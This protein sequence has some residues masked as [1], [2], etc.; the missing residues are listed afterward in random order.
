MAIPVTDIP[1]TNQ[2]FQRPWLSHFKKAINLDDLLE[3]MPESER[4]SRSYHKPKILE[5]LKIFR[6]Y[7]SLNS[8]IN[9]CLP[10]SSLK[11]NKTVWIPRCEARRILKGRADEFLPITTDNVDDIDGTT[12]THNLA[13]PGPTMEMVGALVYTSSAVDTPT[14]QLVDVPLR[15]T[16]VSDEN[17]FV[18]TDGNPVHICVCGDNTYQGMR[19][20][21]N[22][23]YLACQYD[24]VDSG[25]LSGII[26]QEVIVDGQAV[27]VVDF[28]NAIRLFAYFDSNGS[29][30]A[31]AA[32]EWCS[33]MIFSVQYSNAGA[34]R[35]ARMA[36]DTCAVD[37]PTIAGLEDDLSKTIGDSHVC[38]LK[39]QLEVSRL[40][41]QI[42]QMQ[43]AAHT[44]PTA[45][46]ERFHAVLR[47][48][49]ANAQ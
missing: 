18:D 14:L 48:C 32:M 17:E 3:A 9:E 25:D 5:K 44:L 36:A 31:M 38:D 10:L 23:I 37:G 22:H 33:R 43:L 24:H 4:P 45:A 2:V 7:V 35:P 28:R 8:D 42:S 41:A 30:L 47:S 13:Q 6:F 46:R 20:F 49:D 1:T 15:I 26:I 11:R 27:R 29:T 16:D 19:L 12:W 21:L 34:P 40:K 39:H